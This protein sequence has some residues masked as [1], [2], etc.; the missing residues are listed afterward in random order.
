MAITDI[1]GYIAAIGTTGAFIPQAFKVYKTKKTEDLSLG[2][3][4][5]FSTGVLLWTVYGV[6]INSVPVILSNGI[7]FFISCYILVM[8]IK[9]KKSEKQKIINDN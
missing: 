7:T 6:F 4:L 3:F 2:T 9:G 1:V 8:I 5:L